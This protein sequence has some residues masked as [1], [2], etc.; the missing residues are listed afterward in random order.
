MT[1]TGA[2]AAATHHSKPICGLVEELFVTDIDF[3]VAQLSRL[4]FSKLLSRRALQRDVIGLA[5]AEHWD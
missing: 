5:A 1:P 2:S 3:D 4:R